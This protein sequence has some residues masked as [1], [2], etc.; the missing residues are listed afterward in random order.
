MWGEPVHP[1]S[2]RASSGRWYAWVMEIATQHALLYVTAQSSEQAL[3]IGR[4]LV[5]ERLAACANVLERMTSVYIWK[6]RL[7]Q[8]EEAVLLLKTRRE[9]VEQVIARVRE[10]HSY[11]CPCVLALPIEAGNPQFLQWITDETGSAA[12]PAIA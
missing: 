10:L 6:D 9:L 11:D 5:E 2:I 7:E 12:R 4:R 8:S 3:A 1:H